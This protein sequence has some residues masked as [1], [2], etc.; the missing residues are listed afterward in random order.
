MKLKKN[1]EYIIIG[2][3][4]GG[5]FAAYNLAKAGKEVLIVERGVWVKRDESCW[6]EKKL[7]LNDPLYKGLTPAIIDQKKGKLKP[8]WPYDT[9]G[10]MSTFYGAAALR[11]REDDFEGP[12][13]P[14]TDK[15][16]TSAAWPIDY[17]SLSSYYDEAEQMLNVAGIKG[18][19][20]IEP[21]RKK[22]FPQAPPEK[23]S[24]PSKLITDA[25][26]ELGLHP[27]HIPL[28]INFS[29]SNSEQKC[30]LCS[31]CDH[32]ICKL[33][34][35]NDV[36][37]KILPDA[38][39]NGATLLPNTRAIKINITKNR[40]VSIDLINQISREISTIKAKNIIVSCGALS[41]PHLLIA[42]GIDKID[43]S[44]SLIGKYLMR[45]INSIVSGAFPFKT[46]P[47]KM[48]QKQIAI[49]D[50]YYGDK[51]KKNILLGNW[52]I[53]QDVSS[54][55]KGL[56]KLNAPFGLKN[57]AAFLSEYSINLLCI[58]EDIPQLS[59]RV[60]ADWNQKDIFGMP[61][62]KVYHR[63]DQRDNAVI[64]ALSKEAKKILKKAGAKLFYTIPIETFS[65][66]FG[67]CRFG[68]DRSASVLDEDCRVWG[69]KNLYVLDASFMPSGGSVNPSLTIAANSLRV[70]E[71]LASIQ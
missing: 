48:F 58:A 60:Y 13:L 55:G 68:K 9:V 65:H 21:K 66:A 26:K 36:A 6:D 5:A 62:L 51:K 38:I 63:Y 59:N 34:A 70:S 46:N 44:G 20:I 50:F 12:P 57:A 43:K 27:F 15:K 23:L 49:P 33:E 30:I 64:N 14:G 61:S 71:M 22:E 32:Y 16:D 40:V 11:M 31:T 45:H 18:E 10:G 39:K 29:N 3:G 53:I 41:T 25:A 28:A 47:D 37:V 35:K 4:F 17:K 56:I 7:H 19:D 2:S 1:Y 8:D 42:S 54:F 67:S 24:K 69:L 52:G